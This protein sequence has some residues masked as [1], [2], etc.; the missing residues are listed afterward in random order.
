MQQ[1]TMGLRAYHKINRMGY[2]MSSKAIMKKGALDP[3][4]I[5]TMQKVLPSE[6]FELFFRKRTTR[7]LGNLL[8]ISQDKK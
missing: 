7:G 4:R 8:N 3:D 1:Q 6:D 5:A 2:L